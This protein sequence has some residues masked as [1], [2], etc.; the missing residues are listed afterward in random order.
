VRRQERQLVVV[1]PCL[2][3]QLQVSSWVSAA[4]T[5]CQNVGRRSS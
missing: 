2:A 3:S 4:A 5:R 1:K